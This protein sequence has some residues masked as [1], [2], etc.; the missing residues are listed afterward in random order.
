MDAALFQYSPNAEGEPVRERTIGGHRFI[1]VAIPGDRSS[2]PGGLTQIMVNKAH[3]VGF[4]A[5]RTLTILSLP[6]GDFVEVV[7]SAENDDQ[8][9]LPQ[10]GSLK[11]IELQEPWIVPLPTPTTTLWDFSWGLR[12]FQG[13]VTLP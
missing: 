8:L 9:P 4:E 11:S 5:G 3:V 2:L 6:E 12:S 1:N 13:P 7:G 10:G